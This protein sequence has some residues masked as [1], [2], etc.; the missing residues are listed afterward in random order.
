MAAHLRPRVETTT[1]HEGWSETTRQKPAA[2]A[3][4]SGLLG[5]WRTDYEPEHAREEV[6]TRE[7]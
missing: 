4:C 3:K 6:Q 1:N 5:G 2:A 7:D